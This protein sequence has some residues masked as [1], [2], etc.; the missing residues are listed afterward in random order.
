MS[1]TKDFCHFPA[2]VH[3]RPFLVVKTKV[4]V[5][6]ISKYS[7][8]YCNVPSGISEDFLKYITTKITFEYSK[9]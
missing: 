6:N 1:V 3:H 9:H 8:D 2:V 5:L 7:Q 4:T